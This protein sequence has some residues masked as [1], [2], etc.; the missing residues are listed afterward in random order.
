MLAYRFSCY[1]KYQLFRC[2]Y[3]LRLHRP[4]DYYLCTNEFIFY[5]LNTFVVNQFTAVKNSLYSQNGID[6]PGQMYCW[7]YSLKKAV[8][9]LRLVAGSR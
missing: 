6:L 3:W 7:Y 2:L 5:I 9:L 8:Y 4:D 1:N